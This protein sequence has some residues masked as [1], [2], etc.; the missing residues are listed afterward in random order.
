M[1]YVT[2]KIYGRVHPTQ[3]QLFKKGL[4]VVFKFIFT[5]SQK[6]MTSHLSS[7]SRLLRLCLSLKHFC[8]EQKGPLQ[9]WK[10]NA[11]PMIP[12]ESRKALDC[13]GNGTICLCCCHLQTSFSSPAP[14]SLSPC[15]YNLILC[16]VVPYGLLPAICAVRICKE[17][18]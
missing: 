12:V 18:K 7:G 4:G 13:H 9:A 1:C 8:Q 14:R 2:L 6:T 16:H 17:V 11:V 10:G 15:T 3:S 5:L